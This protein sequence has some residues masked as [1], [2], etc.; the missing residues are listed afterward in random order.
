MIDMYYLI[1]GIAFLSLIV[2]IH[3]AIINGVI[4]YRE[5][6]LKQHSPSWIPLLGGILMAIG[7]AACPIAAIRSYWPLAFLLDFGSIPGMTYSALH[8]VILYVSQWRESSKN[9]KSDVGQAV[10]DD[11]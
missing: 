4:A 3:I 7:V 10:S 8:I 6:V 9:K 1:S 5:I 11:D 2:G